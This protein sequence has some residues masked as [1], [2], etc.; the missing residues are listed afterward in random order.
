[1][2]SRVLKRSAEETML[3]SDEGGDSHVDKSM[4]AV[5]LESLSDEKSERVT[6][7]FKLNEIS[8]PMTSVDPTK[9]TNDEIE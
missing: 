3:P 4:S 7:V 2:V 9:V 8:D 1:M 5:I 6:S